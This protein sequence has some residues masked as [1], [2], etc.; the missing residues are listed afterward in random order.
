MVAAGIPFVTRGV[1]FVTRGVPLVT[2]GVP[3]V[4]RGVPLVTHGVPFVTRGVPFV[5]RG[6]LLVTRGVPFVTRGVLF[7]TRGVPLV[8]RGGPPSA[9]I[10]YFSILELGEDLAE[11]RA[12]ISALPGRLA[13]PRHSLWEGGDRFS[14][15]RLSFISLRESLANLRRRLPETNSAGPNRP[16]RRITRKIAVAANYSSGRSKLLRSLVSILR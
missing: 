7:V 1:P 12:P 9:A 15:F 10:S 6:V 13:A 3:F 8:T 2:R 4:T 16:K 11:S 5:T 14:G